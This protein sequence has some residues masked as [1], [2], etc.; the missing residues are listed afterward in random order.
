[1]ITPLK[2][3]EWKEYMV[4]QLRA[5]GIFKVTMGTEWEPNSTTEK[6]KYFNKLDEAYGLLCLSIS[7]EF[8]FHLDYLTLPKEVWEKLESLF[9]KTNELCGHQLENEMISLSL[10]HYDIIQDFFTKFKSLV[11]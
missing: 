8:L 11:L 7:R 2:I 10:A 6:A 1:M 4:I 3:F 5:K 9:G